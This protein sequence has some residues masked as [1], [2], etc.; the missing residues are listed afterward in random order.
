ML[1]DKHFNKLSV[2]DQIKVMCRFMSRKEVAAHF[3]LPEGYVANLMKNVSAHKRRT[4]IRYQ[5]HI[6]NYLNELRI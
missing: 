2:D 6:D 5:N 4:E 3:R 1:L